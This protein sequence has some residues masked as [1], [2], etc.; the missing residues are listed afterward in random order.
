MPEQT[1]E[2]MNLFGEEELPIQEK[3]K[4]APEYIADAQEE[5]QEYEEIEQMEME[6]SITAKT[7]LRYFGGKQAAVRDIL[8]FFPPDI[9]EVVSPFVGGGSVELALA[10]RGVK[11]I[12]YDK[13]DL[14]VNSWNA[15]L[16]DAESCARLARRIYPMNPEKIRYMVKNHLFYNIKDPKKLAAFVWVA[17]K[18]DWSGRLLSATGFADH[19]PGMTLDKDTGKDIYESRRKIVR[20]ALDPMFWRNWRN[21]NIEIREGC[22]TKSL[23]EWHPD[24]FLYAD[25]PYVGRE[26][27]Y[28]VY[29]TKKTHPDYEEFDHEEF[30]EHMIQRPNG[31]VLSYMRDEHGM[32]EDLYKDFEIVD[33]RWHQGSVASRKVRDSKSTKEITI[34]KPPA[35]NPLKVA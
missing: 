25:P 34:I 14:L 28:G 4:F 12:A 2:Q 31:F 6:E 24:A 11:V 32:I 5:E 35:I 21:P 33:M 15:I 23:K 13:F 27:V 19:R 29:R 7:W 16:D 30:A 8:K 17:N 9:T 22:W 26:Y 1:F 20:R 3:P 18:Q 10:V